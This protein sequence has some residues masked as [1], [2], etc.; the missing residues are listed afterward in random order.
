MRTAKAQVP[1]TATGGVMVAVRCVSW[2][3]F[4]LAADRDSAALCGARAD[5]PFGWTHMSDEEHIPTW[6]ELGKVCKPCARRSEV[7][8]L[9]GRIA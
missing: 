3:K 2:R 4:H 1:T 9:A 5:T 7:V 8:K 6:V